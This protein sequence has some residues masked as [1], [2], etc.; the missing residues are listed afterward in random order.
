MTIKEFLTTTIK[1]HKYP[2]SDEIIQ[3]IRP[4]LLCNDGFPS[5]CKLVNFITVV[6]DLMGHRIMKQLSLVIRIMKT[7]SLTTM[8]SVMTIL[9]PF[10][11]M[12]R[13]RLLR[14]S[15]RNTEESKFNKSRRSETWSPILFV[16]YLKGIKYDS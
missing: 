11:D 2:F 4:R 9:G 10:M 1:S 7:N 14:N 3:D 5:R 6:P 13:L 8:P 12:C 16:L 15:L